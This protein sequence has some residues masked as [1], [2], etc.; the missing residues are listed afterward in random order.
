MV[1]NYLV[2]DNDM[3]LE[4][5]T[6]I[7]YEHLD[8]IMHHSE[9]YDMSMRSFIVSFINFV[10]THKIVPNKPYSRLT[11][12]SRGIAEWKRLHLVL[13]EN[14]YEFFLDVKKLWKM[15]LAKIIAFCI[16]N[17]LYDFI[18]AL[19]NT[20]NTDNYRFSGYSFGVFLEEG[21]QCCQFYWG[22]PPSILKKTKNTLQQ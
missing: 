15:S 2:R 20:D 22:P 8:V 17:Y 4:T 6:C 18:E 9:K 14:E 21:I 16:E 11:Y 5:T 7:S 13:L 19:E 12:R 1:K 3:N 10:A